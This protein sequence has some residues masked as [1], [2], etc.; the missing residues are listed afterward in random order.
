MRIEPFK[1]QVPQEEID[2]LGKRLADTRWAPERN[3]EDWSYGVNG[4]YLRELVTY[5]Q[6]NFDWRSQEECIN[7]FPQ[8]R[9]EI[10]G[11]PI[12]F[13]HLRGNGPNPVPIILN[14]GWPWTFWDFK[15]IIMKLAN[16]AAYGGDSA[17]A[18]DVVVPSLPGFTFSGPLSGKVVGYVETAD[19][20]VKLMRGLGYDRFYVHGGDA[21]AFLSARLGHAHPDHVNGVHLSFPVLPGVPYEAGSQAD[22]NADERT[23]LE[24]Q[25]RGPGA[26]YHVLINAFDPQTLAWALHD[27]PVGLAAWILLRRRAWS[28]SHGEVEAKFD[29]DTLLTH[30]SLYWFTNCFVGSQLFC[31]ASKFHM[32]MALANDIKPEISVPTSLA[33]MPKDLMYMPRSVAAAHSDLRRYSVFPSGGHFGAA[34]EP[35]LMAEDIRSFVRPLR[36]DY[37][38]KKR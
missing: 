17:D 18:F 1:I 6:T 27:S 34:E 13:I 9:T 19:I 35:Q 22:L 14:H 11:V 8:F 10:D 3:N 32:P 31:H 37:V 16:P 21:G 38:D 5:W 20:W 15:D 23:I 36:K 29:K 33:I 12:H 26:F 4:T 30:I 28:D 24:G 7:S 2:A 25:A